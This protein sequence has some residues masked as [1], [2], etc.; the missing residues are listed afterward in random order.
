MFKTKV[1]EKIKT[2]VL[3][4]VTFSEDRAVY[5]TMWQSMVEP[6]R[7]RRMRSERWISKATD[8]H[9]EYLRL[10]AF[11]SSG[12]TNVSQYYFYKYI[13]SHDFSIFVVHFSL[14]SFW[15]RFLCWNPNP[16]YLN[17]MGLRALLQM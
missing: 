15:Y 2:Y 5:E 7:P 17:L 16:F 12:C 1:V 14:R 10:I 9:S 13:A 8:T 6:D 4:S 3:C 11:P